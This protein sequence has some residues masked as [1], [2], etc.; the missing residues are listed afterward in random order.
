MV[1]MKVV[2]KAILERYDIEAATPV[3]ERS[4]RRAITIAP[5]SGGRTVFLDRVREREAIPA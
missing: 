3:R 1:E 5:R 2:L 4:K